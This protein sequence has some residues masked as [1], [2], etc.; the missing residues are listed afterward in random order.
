MA[1]DPLDRLIALVRRD[2]GAD[3]VR[4]LEGPAPAV[5]APNVIHAELADGRKLAVA[6]ASA[7]AS[8][9]ALVRRLD[10]LLLTFAQSLEEKTTE[11]K[12]ARKST[13]HSLRDELRVLVA[14]AQATDAVVIDANSPVIWGSASAPLRH[15]LTN[16]ELVDV[17]RSQLVESGRPTDGDPFAPEETPD[18]PHVET[19][20]LT[21]RAIAEIR[22]LPALA[23][24]SKGR[25]LTHMSREESFGCVARSF[26]GIYVLLVVYQGTFDELRAERAIG[27]RLLRIE[28]LVMALPPLDPKPAPTA[29]VMAMRRGR[30]R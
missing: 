2:L 6:F 29:G 26:A 23:E 28:R 17:S 5:A 24:I 19:A 21:S 13:A 8:R 20:S 14:K 25:H 27:E 4:V 1:T 18:P 7:P 30:R 11:G 22:A 10:M 9:D 3:D 12:E 15:E 16:V